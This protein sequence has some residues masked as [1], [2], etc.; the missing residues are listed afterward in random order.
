MSGRR[1]Q[2]GGSR[3]RA[4]GLLII[5]V[6]ALACVVGWGVGKVFI[7]PGPEKTPSS[8][9]AGP[10]AQQLA[11][12]DGGVGLPVDY[13]MALDSLAGKC[14][15]DEPGIATLVDDGHKTL[16]AHGITTLTRLSMLQYLDGEMAAGVAK[17]D[18]AA[19]LTAYVTSKE[20]S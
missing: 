8:A 1:K 13:Q 15:Q 14:T 9:V 16:A 12:A 10:L 11:T 19:P 17:T 4:Y 2:S 5:G 6:L 18:C 3:L 7:S 20:S